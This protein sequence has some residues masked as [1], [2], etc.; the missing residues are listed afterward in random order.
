MKN[1]LKKKAAAIVDTLIKKE[2]TIC[3]AE[4]CT[5]GLFAKT[6][7]DISGV[8]QIYPGG[9]VSY[10]NSVKEKVLGVDPRILASVGAV[11]EETARAMA[12]GV[13]ALLEADIGVSATGIA[14]PNSDGTDKPVGLVYIA[15]ADKDGTTV[16][17]LNLSG[18]R[19]DIRTATVE[20]IFEL[21]EEK[22]K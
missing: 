21:I 11:S 19:D 20:S 5:G 8:S 14:G 4:S 13:R 1:V 10:A 6:M 15:L 7:T 2:L 12:E 9:V 3:S 22:Y 17:K 18:G 16:R